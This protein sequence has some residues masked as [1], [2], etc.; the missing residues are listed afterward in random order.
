VLKLHAWGIDGDVSLGCLLVN[1][2]DVFGPPTMHFMQQLATF[3]MKDEA[4]KAQMLDL[5]FFKAEQKRAAVTMADMLLKYKDTAHPPL[6]A[7][8][9]MIPVMKP[10]AYSIASAPI[11]TPNSIE[12]CVLIDTFWCDGG[13]KYGL[14]CDMLR[15]KDSGSQLWCRIK[16]GSMD[17]P[18]PEQP[19]VCA[20]IGSGLAPH[21]SFLRARV[22]LADAGEE[23]APFA[24]FFG[25]R[26]R[27]DEFL[28][29]E[30]LEA[31]ADKFDWFKLH[32]A[33]SRDQKHKI[34]VQ[35]LVAQTDD[36]REM[37]M[38][39][40]LEGMLYIC[41]N[42]NLP[43]PMQ[44]SLVMS[45]SNRSEDPEEL[46]MAKAAMEDMFVHGRAQQEVW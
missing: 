1:V 20:G 4:R 5:N 30:E 7:L 8:L 46:A 14:T 42:R 36:A 9:A 13:M 45:F 23:V 3:E 41:G 11:A 12:L 31:Y 34:Y 27:K 2:L 25:N 17:P 29:Q 32:T 19:V 38:D 21:L 26:N 44:N 39:S 15:K 10:R 6:P 40:T 16:A 28:Y 33:F 37:L 22:A 18:T 24:V 35:D 43:K